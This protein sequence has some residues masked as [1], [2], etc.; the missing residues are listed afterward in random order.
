MFG[1][2]FARMPVVFQNIETRW[3][4]H[5][6]VYVSILLLLLFYGAFSSVKKNI[7]NIIQ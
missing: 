2:E 7:S 6:G 4:N 1:V 5:V 3:P